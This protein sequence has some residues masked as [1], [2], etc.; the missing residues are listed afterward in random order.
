VTDEAH[1]T[2]DFGA[3]LLDRLELMIEIEDQFLPSNLRMMMS[4]R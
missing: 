2:D 1:F 3:D 4:T